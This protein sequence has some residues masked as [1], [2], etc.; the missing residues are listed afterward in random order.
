MTTL[1]QHDTKILAYDGDCPMCMRTVAM[2]VG[3]GLIAPEQAQSNHSL[4]PDDLAAAQAA[5]IHN[6]LVVIDPRTRETRSGSD[7]LLWIVAEHKG[8]PAVGSLARPARHS[9]AFVAR[10]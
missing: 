2:L 5:G 8:N 9:P 10:L 3:A 1:L 6:Q 4:A 7:A